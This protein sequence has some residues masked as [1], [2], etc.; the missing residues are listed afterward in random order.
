MGGKEDSR[1]GVGVVLIR[2]ERE[3]E[4]S[5]GTQASKELYSGGQGEDGKK[6]LLSLW[7]TF[8]CQ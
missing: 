5:C 8:N 2:Y 4:V 3:K 7:R 1:L 6:V